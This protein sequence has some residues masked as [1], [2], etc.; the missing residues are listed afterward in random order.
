MNELTFTQDNVLGAIS[1]KVLCGDEGV[2][3]FAVKMLDDK[4]HKALVQQSIDGENWQNV[5]TA[6]FTEYLEVNIEGLRAN[7]QYARIAILDGILPIQGSS[8]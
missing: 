5:G 8:I 2:V 7:V 4:T 1:N 3:T 6:S